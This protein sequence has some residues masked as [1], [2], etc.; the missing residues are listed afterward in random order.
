MHRTTIMLPHALKLKAE[1]MA[2]VKRV[3]LGEV[4]REAVERL[5]IDFSKG[6]RRDSIFADKSVFRGPTPRDLAANHD[7]YLYDEDA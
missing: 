5:V 4:I 3:S 2:R 7:H 6:K 1:R